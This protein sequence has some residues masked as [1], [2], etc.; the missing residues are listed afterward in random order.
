MEDLV[1]GGQG[2]DDAAA[3]F[4]HSFHARMN[5]IRRMERLRCV[6]DDNI[7]IGAHLWLIRRGGPGALY[8]V[9]KRSRRLARGPEQGRCAIAV[10]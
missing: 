4:Q 2:D 7:G 1:T 3:L 8:R 5:G 6:V 9:E 10:G